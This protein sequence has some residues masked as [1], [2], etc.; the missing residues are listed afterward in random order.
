M[1]SVTSRNFTLNQR[2][3]HAVTVQGLASGG[4]DIAGQTCDMDGFNQVTAIIALGAIGSSSTLTFYW[5]ESD[6]GTTFATIPGGAMA[7]TNAAVNK[8]IVMELDR[9]KKQYV[10][11]MIDKSGSSKLRSAHY[12]K[13]DPDYAPVM[14][15]SDDVAQ[16]AYQHG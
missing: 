16:T 9:P 4:S 11:I 8:S 5:Q 6:D 7:V 14:V 10:R 15:D 3:E 1:P 12:V 2:V 13:G